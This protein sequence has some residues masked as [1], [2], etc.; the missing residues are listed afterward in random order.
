MAVEHQDFELRQGEKKDLL[1]TVRD[2]SGALL[3][4]TGGTI[5][6]CLAT[7]NFGKTLLMKTVGSGITLS[8]QTTNKGELTVQLDPADTSA[9][10][11]R[12]YLHQLEVTLASV[13]ELVTEG[14]VNLKRNIAQ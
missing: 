1:I 3:D 12:S 9:L 5:K 8:N 2:S 10:E 14:A 11:V 13:P 7:S 6:W 4:L